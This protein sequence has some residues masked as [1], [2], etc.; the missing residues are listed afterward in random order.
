MNRRQA[1]L[2]VGSGAL[3]LLAPKPTEA[4]TCIPGAIPF[5]GGLYAQGLPPGLV[6]LE[7]AIQLPDG[8]ILHTGDTTEIKVAANGTAVFFYRPVPLLHGLWQI[9]K[10]GT[11]VVDKTTDGTFD[12]IWQKVVPASAGPSTVLWAYRHPADDVGSQLR[13]CCTPTGLQ[14]PPMTLW[15]ITPNY[16][17]SLTVQLI[18]LAIAPQTFLDLQNL[19]ST[20]LPPVREVLAQWVFPPRAPGSSDNRTRTIPPLKI[21][22]NARCL[23]LRVVQ[24]PPAS[25]TQTVYVRLMST[26]AGPLEIGLDGRPG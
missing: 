13:G 7:T 20:P 8:T 4:V 6:E 14:P 12:L 5:A 17:G 9:Y 18:D 19:A 22:W 2:G 25:L 10:P 1:L 15:A 3:A 16:F 26:D 23:A 21:P 11:T 24:P